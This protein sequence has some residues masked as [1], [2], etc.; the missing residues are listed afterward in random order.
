MTHFTTLHQ[1]HF[2][3]QPF[4]LPNA[5]DAASA[6]L[7]QQQGAKAV[8]TSSAALAW[9]LGY[10]DGGALPREEL[11]AAIKR[12]VRV[13]DVPLSVDI[14]DGYS[15]SPAAVAQLVL[16]VAQCGVA[17]INLEDGAQ[18]PGVLAEKIAAARH[19]LAGRDLFINARTDVWLR[20]LASGAAAVAM[21][22]E[23]AAQYQK[24]GADGLFVPGLTDAAQVA[25]LAGTNT[26]LPL[27]LMTLP[28]MPP[29]A[30]LF[31]AGARRFSVG[32][33]LFQA[34]YEHGSRL[35]ADFV[36]QRQV[37]PMFARSIGYD[38]MNALF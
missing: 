1:H 10:A 22:Q 12:M 9:S 20:N 25:S 30:E 5:W 2:S 28:G 17:G 26:S 14:E 37:E 24:A 11:L 38:A 31:A 15:S 23:R 16:D 36:Q 13:L 4:L 19:A 27:N 3:D 35:A 21:A 6:R 7:F 8:G 29:I 18:E 34:S 32:P 33:A